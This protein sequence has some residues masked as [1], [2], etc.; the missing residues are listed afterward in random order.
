MGLFNC[1]KCQSQRISKKGFSVSGK[2]RYR[3]K[4]CNYHFTG[5][6]AGKPSH[7]DSTDN[8]E[9]CRRYRL[10][11]KTK[12][13]LTRKHIPVILGICQNTKGVHNEPIY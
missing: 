5:N 1:P 7:P 10:K 4:D 2:Q 13:H 11:K 9:R 3:C 6:P 12:K 8:A